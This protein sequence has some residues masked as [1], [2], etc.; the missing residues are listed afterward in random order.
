M[1]A[2]SSQGFA[3]SATQ[4]RADARGNSRRAGG[5]PA[6]RILVVDDEPLVRWSIA[7]TLVAAGYDVEEAADGKTALT[8]L[9]S[10]SGPSNA[11]RHR[12]IDVVLLDV[13]L[14]D[15]DGLGLLAAMRAAAPSVPI[16]LM[17]A[18]GTT[19]LSQ[20]ATRLGAF[21]VLDKP[22]DMADVLRLVGRAVESQ[23]H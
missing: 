10:H 21:T 5:K 19:E 6:A 23:P 20:S 3:D 8:I 22:F 17:T 7:E 14:P 13:R 9:N 11:E 16:A 1:V 15:A 12:N 4:P 2:P 18:F